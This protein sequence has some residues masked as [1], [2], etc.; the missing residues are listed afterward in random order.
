MD[1]LV[2]EPQVTL[3]LRNLDNVDPIP[4]RHIV[5]KSPK[6]SVKIGRG[7]QSGDEQLRPSASNAWFNSRVMSRSH[8]MIY[9]D[10][11]NKTVHIQDIGSMHGTHF[12]GR[13]LK[14][15]APEPLFVRDVVT[16]G[17]N[18]TRGSN[19][20]TAL[21][22]MADWT[23]S[24]I[25]TPAI[26]TAAGPS[27]SIY[28]NTFSADY[29]E[30]GFEQDPESDVDFYEEEDYDTNAHVQSNAHQD[31][32]VDQ[33]R[34]LAETHVEEVEE[35]EYV[36]LDDDDDDDEAEEDDDE[37]EVVQDSLRE[38]SVEVIYPPR[39]FTV[40]ESDDSDAPSYVSSREESVAESPTS[41]QVDI[42]EGY[43]VKQHELPFGLFDDGK[44]LQ[45]SGIAKDTANGPGEAKNIISDN[46]Q[47]AGDVQQQA[48]A[49]AVRAPSP[50]D[51]AMVKPTAEQSQALA[52]PPFIQDTNHHGDTAHADTAVG[53]ARSESA[54]A[55]HN[56]V[57]YD[58]LSSVYQA[59]GPSSA[60]VTHSFAAL[61]YDSPYLGNEHPW[62]EAES[63]YGLN[64][65]PLQPF[66]QAVNPASINN[67]SE[68]SAR[69][70][71]RKA[72]L[73]TSDASSWD[74]S[75]SPELSSKQLEALDVT[76]EPLSEAD[77]QDVHS[78]LL[79][80][81]VPMQ[82]TEVAM[83]PRKKA[84]KSKQRS[85]EHRDNTGGGFLKIA[86]ATLA[87]MAIGTVGTIIGLASLPPIA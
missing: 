63:Y 77:N 12:A 69:P 28:H 34:Y 3:T 9:A 18:V 67:T 71:K 44:G 25:L 39:T 11:E 1:S 26:D 54:W 22:L 15:N 8:A 40:P 70:L 85:S 31:P 78:P 4:E 20:F 5:L 19:Y 76:Q 82:S 50:S 29:S 83:P 7:T 74:G 23:W 49:H 66:A 62:S 38:P 27:K 84:K 37:V 43:E 14:M 16:L 60:A 32:D 47:S 80:P 45:A 61:T 75:R 53:F 58:N 73:I 51:A 81:D 48:D 13:T 41:S 2:L 6:W 24:D 10:P 17:A 52:A 72:E 57:L 30:D 33:E 59:Q 56:S 35:R 65:P 64:L 36:Q 79:E 55:G 87:G 46:E 86:A 68:S 42:D 21:N